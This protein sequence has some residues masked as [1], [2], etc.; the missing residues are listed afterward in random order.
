MLAEVLPEQ[1]DEWM[2]MHKIVPFGDEK[3][4]VVMALGFATVCN[5]IKAFGGGKESK[6]VEATDFLFWN[7]KKR[8]KATE[9]FVNPNQ[10]ARMFRQAVGNGSR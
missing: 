8:K 5:L 10:A 2:E 7:K 9:S 4:C 6:P 1:F 3:L